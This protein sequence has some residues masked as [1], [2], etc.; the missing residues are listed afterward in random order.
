MPVPSF[1]DLML[2]V[3][4]AVGV[5]STAVKAIR[6]TVART[7]SIGEE[8]QREMLPSGRQEVFVNRVAWALAYL[9]G[10]GLIERIGRGLYRITE[11][12]KK[13]QESPIE[14]V[15]LKFLRTLP[16][17][18]AWR[19]ADTPTPGAAV[20]DTGRATIPDEDALPP[21]EQL[22]HTVGLMKGAVGREVITRLQAETPAFFEQVILDLLIAMGYGGGQID[23]AAVVGQSGDGGIDGVIKEDAL[24]LD[25]I[26]VQAKRYAANNSVGEPQLRDFAGSLDRHRATKGVFVT[27]SNFTAQARDYV[28]H[29]PKRIIL[30]DG[31]ELARLMLIH[32]VG[33]R[34]KDI[35]EILEIDENYFSTE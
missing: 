34:V 26:Y 1:Q 18:Q 19:S 6:E 15:D 21:N 11:Q 23:R 30:I 20:T 31:V 5:E 10:A 33:V 7:M 16:A 2:P 28:K 25:Q 29:S 14:R 3:L 8:A 24:G 22:E 32:K 4:K 35:Y 27:L 13:V 9:Q 12:G 17:F